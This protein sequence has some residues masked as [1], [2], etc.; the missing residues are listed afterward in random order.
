[1]LKIRN[2]RFA[3]MLLTGGLLG[4]IY[5]PAVAAVHIEGHVQAGGG[6]LASSTVTLWAAS[7]GDPKQLA[8]TQTGSDGRFE[9]GADET[10]SQDVSL[11][12]VAKVVWPRST[13]APTIRRSPS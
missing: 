1:M 12:L 9:L 6:P 2:A 13:M 11:Y 3:A 7:V 10:P 8:Q 5:T 4:S